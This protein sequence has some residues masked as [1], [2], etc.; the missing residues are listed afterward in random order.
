MEAAR[1]PGDRYALEYTEKIDTPGPWRSFIAEPRGGRYAA[2]VRRIFGIDRFDMNFHW[3]YA[4][5]GCSVSPHCDARRK[6]GSH[7]FYLNTPDDWKPEWGGQTL[8]LFENGRFPWNSAPRFEDFARA[9]PAEIMGNRSF[10]FRRT[11]H[12]WHGVRELECP[13][14]RMRK[15]FIAVINHPPSPLVRLRRLL[16]DLPGA[17]EA[18]DTARGQAQT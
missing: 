3:H 12:S 9:I 4:P 1:P 5:R 15:V 16:G 2:F 8:V 14:G 11:S 10:L 17:Y 6:L 13:E 7:I 18:P